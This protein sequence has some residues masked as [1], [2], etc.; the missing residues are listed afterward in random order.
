MFGAKHLTVGVNRIIFCRDKHIQPNLSRSCHGSANGEGSLSNMF[1]LTSVLGRCVRNKNKFEVKS[2]EY[3]FNS[4]TIRVYFHIF[5]I[6]KIKLA[7]L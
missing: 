3:I 7:H 5:R 6:K 4:F 2:K 1:K